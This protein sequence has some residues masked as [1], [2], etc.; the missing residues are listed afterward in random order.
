M[1]DAS[2][3]F[4]EGEDWSAAFESDGSD[5]GVDRRERDAFGAGAAEGVRRAK[6]NCG[7]GWSARKRKGICRAIQIR[8][9]WRDTW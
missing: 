3:V 6:P 9:S 1:S 7:S 5:E 2:E 4:I 8:R